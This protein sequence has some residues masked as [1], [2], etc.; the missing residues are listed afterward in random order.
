MIF[1]RLLLLK[2]PEGLRTSCTNPDAVM[3]EQTSFPIEL[4]KCGTVYPT[5]SVL[6]VCLLLISSPLSVLTNILQSHPGGRSR[7]SSKNI[8]RTSLVEVIVIPWMVK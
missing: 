3:R 7:G 4:L 2:P 8:F 1:F 6:R 5:G